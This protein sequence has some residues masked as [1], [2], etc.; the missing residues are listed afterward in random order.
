[1]DD[2]R[3]ASELWGPTVAVLDAAATRRD[4][5]DVV[6]SIEVGAIAYHCADTGLYHFHDHI[7]PEVHRPAD[8]YADCPHDVPAPRPGDGILVLT[9]LA[10]R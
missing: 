3:V 5:L 10:R 8:L 2:R 7:L 9:S 1:M 6:G 4:V